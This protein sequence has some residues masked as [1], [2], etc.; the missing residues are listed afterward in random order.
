[1]SVGYN[2]LEKNEDEKASFVHLENIK[3]Q[4]AL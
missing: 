1:M 4:T 3:S 2:I